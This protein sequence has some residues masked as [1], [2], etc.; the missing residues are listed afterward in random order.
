MKANGVDDDHCQYAA[1]DLLLPH[2]EMEPRV[3]NYG[4]AGDHTIPANSD[5]GN[6]NIVVEG[7]VA[8]NK[9]EELEEES[10]SMQHT[11]IT[12]YE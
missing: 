12:G 1:E 7:L 6:C 10:E 3:Q 4:L 8:G 2:N 9:L 5:D 11:A